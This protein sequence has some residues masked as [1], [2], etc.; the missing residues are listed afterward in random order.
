VTEIGRLGA[1]PGP[2]WRANQTGPKYTEIL[3]HL[4]DIISILITNQV[5][6]QFEVVMKKIDIQIT[7][8]MVDSDNKIYGRQTELR[9]QTKKTGFLQINLNM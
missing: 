1:L 4:P 8:C 9:T 2:G 6:G 5:H 7:A 3:I